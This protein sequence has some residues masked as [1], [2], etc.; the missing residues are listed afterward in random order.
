MK[1]SISLLLTVI[2]TFNF[3]SFGGY[4]PDSAINFSGYI[5]GKYM[6]LKRPKPVL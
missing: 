4:G 6:F 3:L 2:S 5:G 1:L